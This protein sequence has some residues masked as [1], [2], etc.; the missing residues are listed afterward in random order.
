MYYADSDCDV[1]PICMPVALTV[2]I[3][4]LIVLSGMEM[5]A[6]IHITLQ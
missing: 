1:S 3:D 5:C 4:L 2:M 6:I